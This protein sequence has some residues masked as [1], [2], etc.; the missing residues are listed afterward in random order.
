MRIRTGQGDATS[1]LSTGSETVGVLYMDSRMAAADLAGGNRELLQT[2]AIEASTVLENAR[3]LE[4]ER[5]KQK[6]EEE[7]RLARTIQQSLLP[8]KLP[9]DGWL[10]ACGSSVAS[11]EVG[12]D[13]FDVTRVNSRLLVGGGGGRFGQGC[14][15][16]AAG[17]AAAGGADHRDG[18]S[19]GAAAPHG[20]V[21]SLPA[22]T[23]R[24]REIRHRL[25]LPAGSGRA[26]A[27]T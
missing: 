2:L 13:Y 10:R 6:M 8:G 15:F 18:P 1:V 19:R 27:V 9:A 24:R 20:A 7:L 17:V 23:N 3:L 14:Q 11:H 21:E 16:R 26:S 25:L 5:A 12:G 4:E 22:G